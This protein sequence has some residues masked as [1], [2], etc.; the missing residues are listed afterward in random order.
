[1]NHQFHEIELY[2]ELHYQQFH[3]NHMNF[4]QAKLLL[5]KLIGL[6]K[7]IDYI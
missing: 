2:Y 7:K 4:E 3:I 6:M 5:Q 1:M